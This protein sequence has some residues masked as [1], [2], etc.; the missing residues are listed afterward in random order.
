[1]FDDHAFDNVGYVFATID[2][3][4]E[5]FI[6]VLPLDNFKRVAIFV[7]KVADGPLIDVVTFV[8]EAMQFN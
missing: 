8:F 1:M 2:R 3:V 6:H 7:E 4:F 5:L